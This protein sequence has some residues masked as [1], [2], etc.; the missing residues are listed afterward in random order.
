MRETG[1]RK[2]SKLIKSVKERSKKILQAEKLKEK[3]PFQND[4]EVAAN[5]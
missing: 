2:K 4:R 3:E 5:A 1:Q